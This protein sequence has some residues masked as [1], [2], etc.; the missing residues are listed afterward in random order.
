MQ[1]QIKIAPSVL[2]ADFTKLG[3]DLADV[4]CADFIHYDVMD[5]HFVPNV[6]FG[7]DILKATKRATDLPVDVHLMISNPD[8]MLPAFIDAGADLITFHMEATAHAN[9]LIQLIH[10]AGRKAS[11]AICPAT[12]VCM[13][14]DV[15]EDVD[16]VLIMTVNPGFGGQSFLESSAAKLRRVKKLCAEHG[17]NPM[18]EVDGGINDETAAIVAGAGVN[19]LVAGS[20]VFGKADRG[21]AIESIR[22]S[23]QNALLKKA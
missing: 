3:A 23:A 1:S 19:V 16:M 10:A 15:I 9:R 5:G 14:E 6:S 12:P 22:T 18:I 11:V 8:E 7:L 13:L 4:A 17:V 2:S 20:A 21:A